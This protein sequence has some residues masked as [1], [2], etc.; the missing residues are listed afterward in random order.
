MFLY[1]SAILLFLSGGLITLVSIFF[2]IHGFL[3]F[4]PDPNLYYGILGLG[5]GFEIAKVTVSTFLF[6]AWND[7]GFPWFIKSYMLVAV[8]SLIAFS[9]IFTFVHLNSSISGVSA[10]TTLNDTK[11]TQLQERNKTIQAEIDSLNQQ[12]AAIPSNMNSAR[13]RLMDKITPRK[14]KLSKELEDNS[15]TISEVQVQTVK[16]DKFVF[17]T[18]ISNMTGMS[19]ESIVVKVIL[20]IVL[21][22]DPLAISLFLAA[23]FI[24]SKLKPKVEEIKPI[25]RIIPEAIAP[26]KEPEPIIEPIVETPPVQEF[27]EELPIEK[28]LNSRMVKMIK[29]QKD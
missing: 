16:D 7:K 21:S 1:L 18:S 11:V 25:E 6:H 3:S 5:I 23:S 27:E 10:D 29:K 13:M 15:R 28:P 4:V 20:F 26:I 8:V 17:L 24:L 14:D 2:S 19:R 9:S 12:V 22:I